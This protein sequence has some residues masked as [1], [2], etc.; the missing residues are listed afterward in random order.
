M[1]RVVVAR[2]CE[3]QALFALLTATSTNVLSDLKML[4]GFVNHTLTREEFRTDKPGYFTNDS[5]TQARWWE[6]DIA[7]VLT[8]K[9]GTTA[10]NIDFI[11]K[12]DGWQIDDPRYQPQLAVMHKLLERIVKALRWEQVHLD[13][14]H[15]S[16]GI[17]LK[18]L[19]RGYGFGKEFNGD[20]KYL[21]VVAMQGLGCDPFIRIYSGAKQKI[22]AHEKAEADSFQD[23]L[24]SLPDA[25]Q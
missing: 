25:G 17:R 10:V 13:E 9:K 7:V 23:F 19:D 16:I 20:T 24:N 21:A 4:Q 11:Q 6:K 3:V 12:L 1:K 8:W 18:G 14:G 5:L 15:P 22:L 2:S